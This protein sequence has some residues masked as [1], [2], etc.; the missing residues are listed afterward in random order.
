MKRNPNQQQVADQW[1]AM[2]PVGAEVDVR[3]DSGEVIRT[4]TRTKAE[5]LSGHTAV[6]WL[7]GVRGCYALTH[8]KACPKTG[9]GV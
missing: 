5:V 3:K 2:V 4:T 8:V 9:V 6:V 1:N 7:T